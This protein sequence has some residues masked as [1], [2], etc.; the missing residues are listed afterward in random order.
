MRQTGDGL[1]GVL[2][3][4][5]KASFGLLP[6]RRHDDQLSVMSLDDCLEMCDRRMDYRGLAEHRH[7]NVKSR[8]RA[9]GLRGGHA[10]L[11]VLAVS[12]KKATRADHG[13]ED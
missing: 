1:D 7:D 12:G 2:G 5:A 8:P 4:A 6:R 13:G 10:A 3:L 9:R 11:A